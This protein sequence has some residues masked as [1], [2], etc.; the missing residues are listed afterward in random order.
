M[1]EDELDAYLGAARTCSVAT[2]GPSGPHLS[3]LWFV[4]DGDALWLY[5]IV[6]SQRWTDVMRDPRVAILVEA[7]EA[8]SELQ[9]VEIRGSAATV[10]EVPRTGEP[11]DALTVPESLFAR[12]YQGPE[13]PGAETP[14]AETPKM[15]YDGRHAWLRITPDKITSWDFRKLAQLA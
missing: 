11:N 10:G 14:N 5:S 7:G 3:A 1:T 8:Y 6:K 13:T 9:G 12:K 2:I 4:W 15:A